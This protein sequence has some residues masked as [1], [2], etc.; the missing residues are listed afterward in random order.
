MPLLRKFKAS[1]PAHAASKGGDAM[2]QNDVSKWKRA[3][4]KLAFLGAIQ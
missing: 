1:N 3:G 4:L 2:H